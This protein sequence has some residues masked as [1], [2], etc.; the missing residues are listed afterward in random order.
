MLIINFWCT[1]LRSTGLVCIT[2]WPFSSFP[3]KA[4]T[5]LSKPITALSKPI[6]TL[7]KTI[8]AIT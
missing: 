6:T 1:L 4:L 3:I 2:L 7:S 8:T 5:A